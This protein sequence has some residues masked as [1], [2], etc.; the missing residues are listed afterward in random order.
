MKEF[1]KTDPEFYQ[2]ITDFVYDE[3]CNGNPLEKDEMY[4][5]ILAGLLGVQENRTD[6]K[7][8]RADQ[9]S[10]YDCHYT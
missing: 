7:D 10:Y 2:I 6:S 3:A 4:M 9:R 5:C 1:K 8:Q